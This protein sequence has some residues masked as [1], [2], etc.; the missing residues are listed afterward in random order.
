[1]FEVSAAIITILNNG[2]KERLR[3]KVPGGRIGLNGLR[4]DLGLTLNLPQWELRAIHHCV[5]PPA[6][7]Y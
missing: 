3:M 1:L 7:M 4:I 5:M 2:C 6:R